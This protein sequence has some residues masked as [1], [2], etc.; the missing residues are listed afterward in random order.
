[1]IISEQDTDDYASKQTQ[2]GGTF[3]YGSGGTVNFGQ[4]KV[5]SHLRSVQ[6]QSGVVAA[7]AASTSPWAATR[8]W[9]AA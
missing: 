9:K 7:A 4:Q 1:S 2:A 5:E 8:T 6:E 3:V